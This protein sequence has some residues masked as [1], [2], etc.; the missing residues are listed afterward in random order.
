MGFC[1]LNTVAI[2]ANHALGRGLERVAI[3]DWDVHHGNGTQDIFYNSDRVLF[4]STHRYG[5][6]YPG[7][8][9]A[10]ERGEG[11]G[12]GFT[13]NVPLRP[14]D[15]DDVVTAAFRDLV[16]P[17]V[18]R[19]TPD[20]VPV[21]AGF[22]AHRD[23]P[24]GGLAMTESGFHQLASMTA[25]VADRAADGRLV[26]VLEG[27]YDPIALGNSVLATLAAFDGEPLPLL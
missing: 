26:A 4:C 16:L 17:A 14:G 23:D 8:G 3:V 27:G 24:L 20:L 1:L 10:R 2:A 13:L 25:E 22:D 21:S 15:G 11:R 7:T 6:F 5:G 19:F 12:L 18:E 9:A